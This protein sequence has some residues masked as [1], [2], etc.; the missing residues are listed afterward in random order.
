MRIREY[1][2]AALAIALVSAFV[3]SAPEQGVTPEPPPRGESAQPLSPV[4]R[5]RDELRE[6]LEEQLRQRQSPG[7]AGKSDHSLRDL[8]QR[9]KGLAGL[10]RQRIEAR[11]QAAI[12]QEFGPMAAQLSE[13]VVLEALDKRGQPIELQLDVLARPLRPLNVPSYTASANSV[14][15]TEGLALA[16]Y[17]ILPESVDPDDAKGFQRIYT[18][19]SAQALATEVKLIVSLK[20]GEWREAEGTQSVAN[21]IAVRGLDLDRGLQPNGNKS[22]DDTM[23]IVVE[24]QDA[25]S[26]VYEY[27]MTTES[28]STS[29]GVGR[30]S[31]M[32]VVYVR[33]LHRGKDP[34]YRLKGDA[35]DGTRQG[36]EG[37]QRIL[38][39]NIHSAYAKRAIDSSTPLNPNVSLGCQVVAASKRDFEKMLVSLLDS[40]GIKEFPYTIVDGE[41][42]AV[43]NRALEERGKHALLVAGIPRAVIRTD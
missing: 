32:Q 34:A 6:I 19:D 11:I 14:L 16:L 29:R 13:P 26:E 40:K 23:Y 17:D 25:G 41:E 42:L 33:G 8:E 18:G 4:D 31:S 24:S 38:G 9:A 43:L 37:T 1:A 20:G 21:A 12:E 5:L 39:A 2:S 30:L 35:A 22:Y 10:I 28:S 36:V 27:R 15:E 3:R 7:S